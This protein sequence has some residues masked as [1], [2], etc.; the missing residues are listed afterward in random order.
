MNFNHPLL[1]WVKFKKS[2]S[3]VFNYMGDKIKPRETSFIIPL[4]ILK[5]LKNNGPEGNLLIV[6]SKITTQTK[7][8][9]RRILCICTLGK[10]C[11]LT[12]INVII[13]GFR[14]KRYFFLF[15]STK[16]CLLTI[17]RNRVHIF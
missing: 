15:C 5:Y 4:Q 13:F 17:F 12:I 11:S 16:N 10:F 2:V 8:R 6:F 9:T 7:R 3:R 14:S 1:S